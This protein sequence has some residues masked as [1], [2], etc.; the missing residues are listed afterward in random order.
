M[1][2]I[3]LLRPSD[4]PA[5]M[6]LKDAAGWNQTV[7]DWHALFEAAPDGCFGIEI[8]GAIAAT[9]TVVHYGAELAWIG[10]VLTGARYRRLGLA[11]ALLEHVLAYAESKPVDWIKLDATEM[12]RSLYGPFGFEEECA[13]ER[14]LRP[15][16]PPI[17]FD[18]Q[19]RADGVNYARGRPGSIAAYFGPCR[20][21]SSAAAREL[22]QW[23]LDFHPRE[24]IFW[25]LFPG[26]ASAVELAT[27]H[28]FAPARRLVRM[29]RRSRPNAPPHP[30]D[31]Q[32]TYAIA[33][34]EWG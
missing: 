24:A 6:A 18:Q 34:F 10:M 23:F 13:V 2:E 5:C 16:A 7:R 17:D 22:L 32:H 29:A 31:I 1:Y 27:A 30:T 33:G 11:R 21:E 26:N 4:L 28:G 3:R 12:G 8:D 19:S 25:D 14:W 9:T 15:G 20:A